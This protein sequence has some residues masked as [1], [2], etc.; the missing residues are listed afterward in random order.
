MSKAK[1]KPLVGP[2]GKVCLVYV[3]VLVILDILFKAP[4]RCAK[5]GQK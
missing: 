1:K 5:K 2:I 4:K 3:G